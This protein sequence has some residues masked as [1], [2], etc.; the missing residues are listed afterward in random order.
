MLPLF[1]LSVLIQLCLVLHIIKTDSD[2]I[3]IWAVMFAPLI[4]SLAYFIVELL[5][6]LRRTRTA[7]RAMETIQQKL[8]PEQALNDA[9]Q[10]FKVAATVRNAMDV[11]E[12]F[13][14]LKRFSDARDG[15]LASLK[16]VHA[17]DPDLVYGLA[18]AYMGLEDYAATIEILDRLKRENP[19]KTSDAGH[20]LYA[21]ALECKGDI[22]QAQQEYESLCGYDNGSEQRCRLAL[23]H[24]QRGEYQQAHELW[25]NVV[26]YARTAGPYFNQRQSEWIEMAQREVARPR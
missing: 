11:A 23:I 9:V 24:Q 8:Y 15:Y 17:H 25:K 20:L 4:G 5:P 10:R 12:Q 7:R 3:W 1:G 22:D 14:L 6:E 18:E 2:R 19:E 13:L 21:R 16:G 26:E